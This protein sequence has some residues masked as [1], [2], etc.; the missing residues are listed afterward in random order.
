[1]PAPSTVRLW[2][3]QDQSLAEQYARARESLYEHWADEL[4]EISDDGSNDYMERLTKNGDTET[5]VN[6]EHI[7]RSRLR[8]DSRKWLLSKLLPKKY[9]DKASVELTGKDGGP[10]QTETTISVVQSIMA[11]IDGSTA[12]V[13]L[14][15]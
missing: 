4:L 9:G 14:S 11:E 7:N 2:V 6:N 1:M 15:E 10:V 13:Q 12:H 8:V 3:L 5:V